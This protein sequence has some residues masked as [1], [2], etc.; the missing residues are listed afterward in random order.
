VIGA[1]VALSGIVY[2]VFPPVGLQ[3]VPNSGGGLRIPR[4]DP[5]ANLGGQPPHPAAAW[6]WVLG[7]PLAWALCGWL[8]HRRRARGLGSRPGVI[9]ALGVLPFASLVVAE[10]LVAPAWPLVHQY[11][12]NEERHVLPATAVAVGLA[13]VALWERDLGLGA[14]AYVLGMGPGW[15]ADHWRRL[16]SMGTWTAGII[17]VESAM[18]WWGIVLMSAAAGWE[19]VRRLRTAG[20]A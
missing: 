18:L 6:F 13:L 20:T 1:L 5:W 7:V 3:V 15:M 10:L 14:A 12:D 16:D 9:V 17:N 2:R 19:L 11:L 4:E 8:Y